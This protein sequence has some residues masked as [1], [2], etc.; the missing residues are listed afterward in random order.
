MGGRIWLESELGAGSTFHFTVMLREAAQGSES[1][2][3]SSDFGPFPAE[4]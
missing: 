1:F 3:A 4:A 2:E